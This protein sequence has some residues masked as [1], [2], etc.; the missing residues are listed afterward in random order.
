VELV[1][2]L[3]TASEEVADARAKALVDVEAFER[4]RGERD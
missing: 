3:A 4:L 2:Q 1:E